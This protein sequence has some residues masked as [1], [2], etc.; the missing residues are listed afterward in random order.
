MKATIPFNSA[1]QLQFFV[2]GWIF[3]GMCEYFI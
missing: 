1:L 2:F 3:T